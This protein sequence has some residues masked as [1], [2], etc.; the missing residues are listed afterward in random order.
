MLQNAFSRLELHIY[1]KAVFAK[2]NQQKKF[3]YI[4]AVFINFLSF[5]T[6]ML[7]PFTSWD[8]YY[9]QCCQNAVQ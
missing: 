1:L 5:H 2:V 3:D 8:K 6:F 9:K 7:G 4:H